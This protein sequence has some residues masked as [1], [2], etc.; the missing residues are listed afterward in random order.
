M[1]NE[2]A[3]SAIQA[4]PPI[5]VSSWQWWNWFAGHDLNWYLAALVSMATLIY[6]G[7]QSYY[8]IRNNRKKVVE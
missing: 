5:G 7:L 4:A 6:I 8:L 3:K 2:T 1:K